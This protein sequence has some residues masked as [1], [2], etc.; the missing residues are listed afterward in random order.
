MRVMITG[1]AGMLG[2]ACAARLLQDGHRVLGY[3]NLGPDGRSATGRFRLEELGGQEEFSFFQADVEDGPALERALADFRPAAVLHLAG[4]R[5]L[6]WAERE[7]EQ[8]LRLHGQGTITLLHAC[9]RHSVGQLVLA[10]SY[11]VYGGSRRFPFREDDAA[12]M[13]LSVLGAALRAAELQAYTFALRSPVNVSVVRRFSLYG[14]GQSARHL[15]PRLARAAERRRPMPL[16]GDGTAARDLL[17]LDDAVDFVMR[18]LQRPVPW[19][20][21]NLGS[22]R[23]TTLGQVAEQLSWLADVVFQSQN[24]APRPGEMPQAWADMRRAEEELGFSARV[25]LAEGLRRY[26]QW[27]TQRPACFRERPQ[28]RS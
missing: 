25:D 14:P 6:E 24:L 15:V 21:V 26:W 11:H 17:Y 12:D 18:V 23:S 3:D 4:R 7:P 20:I 19:R 16:Y 10:S 5:D 22:G 8:A 28:P 1:A 9:Q 2:A 13:P 27:H